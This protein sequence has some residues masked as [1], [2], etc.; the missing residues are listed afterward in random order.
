MSGDTVRYGQITKRGNG[1]LRALLV[2]ASWALVK[3]KQGGKLKQWYEYMTVTKSKSK[4]K[5]IVG[6]ARRLSEL[7]YVLMRDASWYVYK[8]FKLE[9]K[10]TVETLAQEA[11]SA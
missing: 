8:P 7:L 9:K 4:K 3:T 10:K 2:Q 6:V 5:A 1:Y 11:L